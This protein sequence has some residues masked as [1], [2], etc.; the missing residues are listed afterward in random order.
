MKRVDITGKYLGGPTLNGYSDKAFFKEVVLKL[1]HGEQIFISSFPT[2]ASVLGRIVSWTRS[3]T[4]FYHQNLSR[5]QLLSICIV[6]PCHGPHTTLLKL[7]P[8]FAEASWL[9]LQFLPFPVWSQQRDAIKGEIK[10]GHPSAQI[11]QWL[12]I[13]RV[14]ARCLKSASAD[15]YD[16]IHGFLLSLSVAASDEVS[17][18]DPCHAHFMAFVLVLPSAWNTLPSGLL[19]LIFFH[20]LLIVLIFGNLCRTVSGDSKQDLGTERSCWL[21]LPCENIKSSVFFWLQSLVICTPLPDHAMD[22]DP[23]NSGSDYLHAMCKICH[24]RGQVT[25]NSSPEA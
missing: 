5:I 11:L 20:F 21:G 6:Q 23:L 1:K 17:S 15:L 8:R 18:V 2:A 13:L 9:V 10:F 3:P 19:A 12:P 7:Q 22:Q 4:G 24:T 25:A 16:Q 14:E